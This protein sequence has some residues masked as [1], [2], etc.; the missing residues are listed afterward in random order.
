MVGP[1][2]SGKTSLAIKL[3]KRFGGELVSVDSVQVYRGFNIG[4]AKASEAELEGVWQWMVDV[5]EPSQSVDAARYARDARVCVEQ[6]LRRRKRPILVGGTGLWYRALTRGLAPLPSSDPVIRQNLKERLSKQGLAALWRE[7]ERVDAPMASRLHPNDALRI[8]RALEVYE[9]TGTPLSEHHA[10]HRFAVPHWRVLRLQIEPS[11]EVH[12]ERIHKRVDRMIA[13]GWVDEVANLIERVGPQ[14][15][16]MGSLGYRQLVAY[17][18]SGGQSL[19]TVVEA[20]KKATIAYARHQR[21][22]FRGEPGERWLLG[23]PESAAEHR[24]VVDEAWTETDAARAREWQPIDLSAELVERVGE[25]LERRT[26]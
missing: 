21:T 7:L 3:A 16:P 1:T 8:A 20:V 25:W 18:Q 14:V 5:Y 19:E 17:L 6:V 10:K 12:R 13:A 15:K 26:V 9:Q 22:W 4:S 23:W 2:A 11:A 24:R